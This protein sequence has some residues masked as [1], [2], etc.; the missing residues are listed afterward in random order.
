MVNAETNFFENSS[1]IT[2][3]LYHQTK[4]LPLSFKILYIKNQHSNTIFQ[5]N[6]ELR[7]SNDSNLIVEKDDVLKNLCATKGTRGS[8]NS[9]V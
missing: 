9:R 2:S 3:E 7:C 1:S 8:I 5:S 4:K 6:H